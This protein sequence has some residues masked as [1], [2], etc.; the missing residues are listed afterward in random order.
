[1]WAF[2]DEINACDHLGFLNGLIC[3]HLLEG[4]ALHMDLVILAACNPYRLHDIENA[5]TGFSARELM[6]PG[7]SEHFNLAYQ[8][9]PLPEAMLDY[10]WDFGLLSRHDE[11]AYIE[12]MVQ[13]IKVKT[14]G[15]AFFTDLLVQSQAFIRQCHGE[16]SVSLRDVSRCISLYEW[17]LQDL[18]KRPLLKGHKTMTLPVRAT[19]LAFSHCYHSRLATEQEREQYRDIFAGV[20]KTHEPSNFRYNEIPVL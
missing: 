18:Q 7:D 2:L 13:G 16:A 9:H 3:H 15:G 17:F 4:K 6:N 10:V 19:L 1:M 5:R 20:M 11:Q 8:V 14:S 12:A